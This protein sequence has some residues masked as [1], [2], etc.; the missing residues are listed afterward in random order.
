MAKS[1]QRQE[2]TLP[3]SSSSVTSHQEGAGI[4]SSPLMPLS[5]FIGAPDDGS[6]LELFF[7]KGER[8]KKSWYIKGLCPGNFHLF[9]KEFLGLYDLWLLKKKSS[10]VLV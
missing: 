5:G 6:I 3:L 8:K 1:P 7:K 9:L 2:V 4:D 10:V